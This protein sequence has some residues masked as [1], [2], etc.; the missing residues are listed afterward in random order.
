[1]NEA[2]FKLNEALGYRTPTEIEGDC[3][4][5]NYEREQSIKKRND[6]RAPVIFNAVIVP[7]RDTKVLSTLKKKKVLSFRKQPPI[8]P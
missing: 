5:R 3:I 8:R 7:S 6:Q 4:N 1:M 2:N